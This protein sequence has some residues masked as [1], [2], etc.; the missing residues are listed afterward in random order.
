MGGFFQLASDP[1]LQA[2]TGPAA[3]TS[4]WVDLGAQQFFNVARLPAR[5]ALLNVT[6][7]NATPSPVPIT[8]GA[9]TFTDG[10]GNYFTNTAVTGMPTSGS[11]PAT[12]SGT[13][14][15]VFTAQAPGSSGNLPAGFLVKPVAVPPGIT[16]SL[17]GIVQGGVNIESDASLIARCLNQW[18]SLGTGSPQGVWINWCFAASPEVRYALAA[19]DGFG[20]VTVTVY[21]QGAPVSQPGL[22]AIKAYLDTRIPQC[23]QL[24]QPPLNAASANL[25]VSATIWGP[26]SARTSTLAAAQ[27]ALLL[28]VAGT[29]IGGFPIVAGVTNQYG[30]SNSDLVT[31][32]QNSSPAITKVVVTVNGL[33]AGCDFTMAPQAGV[34]VVAVLSPSPVLTWIAV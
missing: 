2:T 24:S 4:P 34:P 12:G 14:Q 15:L 20:G 7:T 29:P 33:P 11:V 23:I 30:I 17:A 13:L 18:T 9:V 21:G 1:S 16:L 22:D 10:Q 26:A 32:I 6:L 3:G 31:A 19:P 5:S 28:L 25:S 8:T 27:N